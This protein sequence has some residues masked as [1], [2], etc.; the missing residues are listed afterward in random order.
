MI[1]SAEHPGRRR[2]IVTP[3][4]V[5]LAFTLASPAERAMAFLLDAA[6]II[7]VTI[8]LALL[9][10]G[11]TDQDGGGLSSAFALLV[12]FFLRNF[13]FTWFEIS[14]QGSTP[15]KRVI[16]LRVIDRRGGVLSADA[17]FARNLTR[18]IE[19]FM[20]LLLLM[21]PEIFDPDAPVRHLFTILWMLALAALPLLNRDHLRV[22]DL[23]GG[24]LVVHAPKTK[25]LRDLGTA[26]DP[27]RDEPPEFGFTPAQLDMYGVRELQVLEDL[28]RTRR[29]EAR[30]MRDVAERIQHKIAWSGGKLKPRDFLDAFYR[31]QR[32]RLEHELLLG[33]ARER[34]R[35]GRLG[36][37]DTPRRDDRQPDD[38]QPGSQQ[39]DDQGT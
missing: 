25:L 7:A 28:L 16:G 31:A 17:V 20:P 23:V 33:K 29:H 26:A 15:G 13:Y 27:K 8:L 36:Q 6:L 5:P 12:M 1:A 34:K 14:W 24:T 39:P 11:A 22:G 18:E 30:T 10:Y 2:E 3:E 4:G 35:E 9:L 37:P 19:F 21:F 32:A 38:Q